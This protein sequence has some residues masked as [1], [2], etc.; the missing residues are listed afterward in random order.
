ME[1]QFFSTS[2]F[3]C[4]ILEIG[5]ELHVVRLL[6]SEAEFSGQSPTVITGC[7]KWIV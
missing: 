7:G 5:E 6:E 1:M 4:C 3:N 2:I